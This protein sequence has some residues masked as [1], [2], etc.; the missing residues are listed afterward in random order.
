MEIL[1]RKQFSILKNIN[2]NSIAKITLKSGRTYLY[3]CNLLKRYK[4]IGLITSEKFKNYK[5]IKLTEKGIILR[6]HLL[7]IEELLNE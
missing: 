2:G 5:A 3:V 1:N 7:A 4:E 6:N